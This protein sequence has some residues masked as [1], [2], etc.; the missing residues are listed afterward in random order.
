MKTTSIGHISMLF[1]AI[2]WG[3]MTPIG[4]EVMSEGISPI[5]LT[6]FRMF[7]GAVCF[8]AIALILDGYKFIKNKTTLNSLFSTDI[9]SKDFVKLFFAGMLG[10]MINQTAFIAGLGLTSPINASIVTTSTPIITMIIAAIYLKEPV[11][12]KKIIGI[13]VGATGAL[14][15]II[16]STGN[17][18]K[19]GNIFG[20]LLCFAGQLST[21]LY[22]TLFKDI[23]KKYGVITSMK[24]MFT[25]SAIAVI[26]FSYSDISI[27]KISNLNANVIYGIL[28]IVA[29]GTFIA[30]ILYATGQKYLR[31]TVIS[32]YN[33]VQPIVAALVAV[34]IGMDHFGLSKGAAM[35]LVFTGVYIVNKSKALST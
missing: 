25:Y 21:A 6:T 16:G 1:A 31:P 2:L 26:P 17:S 34:S 13:F 23:I 20:D 28:F 27:I 10:V 30:Y 35:I 22:L 29:G 11:T 33:Y 5:A 7:G 24:W 18:G 14:I 19:N 8:W 12:S 4:K 3:L 15:L 9:E 32:M